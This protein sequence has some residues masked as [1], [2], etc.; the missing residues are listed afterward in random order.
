VKYKLPSIPLTDHDYKRI[1]ELKRD[2]RYRKGR[3]RK[4]LDFFL[5]IKRKCELEAFAKYGLTAIVDKYLPEKLEN[6]KSL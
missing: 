1:S 6:A 2:P 5:K 3:W 4:Q